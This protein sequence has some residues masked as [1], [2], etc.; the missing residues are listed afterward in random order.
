[1]R[2]VAYR[3]KESNVK[4]PECGF[5]SSSV[6][7]ECEQCGHRFRLA[8]HS[9]TASQSSRRVGR[10][11]SSRTDWDSPTLAEAGAAEDAEA[12]DPQNTVATV[13]ESENGAGGEPWPDPGPATQPLRN[14]TDPATTEE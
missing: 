7:S 8:S 2:P 10:A 11:V 9:K 6:P 13:P 1:M 3:W 14:N 4:C 12:S 5:V